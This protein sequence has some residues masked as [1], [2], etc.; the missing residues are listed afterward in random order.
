MA[1]PD[2]QTLTLPALQVAATGDAMTVAALRPLIAK[3]LGLDEADL[4]ERIPSGRQT[5]FN[6]RVNW[7]CTYLSQAGLLEKVSRGTYRITARGRELVAR[8]PERIDTVFMSRYPEFR[9]WVAKSNQEEAVVVDA[10]AVDG[11]VGEAPGTPEEHIE[12]GYT[13]LRRNVETELITRILASSPAFFENLVVELL[14]TM[15]YGGSRADAG[16]ALGRSGDGGL[17]GIIKEDKLGLDA[18]YIQAKRY[19]PENKVSRPAV[20]AFAGSLEGVRARKGVFITTSAFS[21]EAHDYVARIEKKIILIDGP[22]LAE[23]LFDH[24]VGVR[25]KDTYEVKELDE[26]YFLDD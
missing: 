8:P 3:R 14:V 26:E 9:A 13:A 22:R 12:A 24:G 20:Q 1:C 2:F 10:P 11:A 4:A 19:A 5:R 16:Q 18:I 7:A 25:T 17:D 15:G 23:L 6:N 21:S